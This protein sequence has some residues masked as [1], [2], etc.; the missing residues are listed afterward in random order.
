[1]AEQEKIDLLRE[2]INHA[3]AIVVGGASGM[4]AAA[5]FVFYYQ[6]DEVFRSIVGSLEDKYGFHNYFDAYYHRG[7]TRGEHWA[8]VLRNTKY[9]YECYTGEPYKDLAKLLDGKNYYIATTNQDMQ[10]Y[11]TFPAEKITC[12][13][14]NSA[15]WQCSRPCHDAIYP[16]KEQVFK[17]CEHIENDALPEELIPRCPKC[18]SEMEPW[19]RGYTFLEGSYYHKEMQRYINFLRNNSKRNTLFLELG[20]GMMTPMFIKE[21]FINMTYQWPHAF[22]ATINPQHAIVPDE[23]ADRSLAINDDIAVVMKQ[24][25]G[26]SS[27]GIKHIDK[28]NIFNPSRVY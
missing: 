25:L 14:G 12:I 20:V 6:R 17:L 9:L 26:M 28:G 7:H 24:L 10:F 19:V 8:M 27:D 3:D 16:N 1:M 15:Y 11:R 4:S 23:I 5:G 21:P 2:K 13:Q 22:Y 18:G